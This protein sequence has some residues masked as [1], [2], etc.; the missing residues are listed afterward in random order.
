MEGDP[1]GE[2]AGVGG[3]GSLCPSRFGP[4]LP[5]NRPALSTC[6][7]LA[8]PCPGPGWLLSPLRP[9]GELGREAEPLARVERGLRDV[10]VEKATLLWPVR[11]WGMPGRIGR[12]VLLDWNWLAP[13]E[14]VYHQ[15]AVTCMRLSALTVSAS[16]AGQGKSLRA[17]IVAAEGQNMQVKVSNNRSHFGGNGR[18]GGGGGCGE[19]WGE[20]K[21][22]SGGAWGEGRGGKG[23]RGRGMGR[24]WGRSKG[25]SRGVPNI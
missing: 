1:T 19:V 11:R 14:P 2:G 24:G 22:W 3:G 17:T 20:K 4:G 5:D 10:C 9:L 8:G 18:G 12:T 15:M 6:T 25:K 16:T 21:C 23:T 13:P 7:A